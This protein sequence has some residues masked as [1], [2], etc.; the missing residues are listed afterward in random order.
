LAGKFGVRQGG[1]TGEVAR[2]DGA[3][4]EADL[5]DNVKSD[6]HGEGEADSDGEQVHADGQAKASVMFFCLG[7]VRGCHNAP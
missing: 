2:M 3:Y 4:L 6:E 1:E 7:G 5:V